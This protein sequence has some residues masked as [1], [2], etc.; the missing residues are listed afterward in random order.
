MLGLKLQR[1]GKVWLCT[2]SFTD[3]VTDRRRE[4]G[5]AQLCQLLDDVDTGLLWAINDLLRRFEVI[6]C[7][8]LEWNELSWD[9]PGSLSEPEASKLA[10]SMAQMIRECT[11]S[12]D[13]VQLPVQSST[14][15]PVPAHSV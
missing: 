8:H 11:H 12:S 5:L 15:P 4:V 10:L 6:S 13:L 2:V 3:P 7:V 1:C 14:Q 9:L